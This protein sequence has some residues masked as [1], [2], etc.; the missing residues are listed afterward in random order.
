MRGRAVEQTP[1]RLRG[2]DLQTRHWQ[3]VQHTKTIGVERPSDY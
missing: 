3:N 2:S 1:E